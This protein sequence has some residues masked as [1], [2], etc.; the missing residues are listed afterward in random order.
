[1]FF[2]CFV[3]L[4]IFIFVCTSV[5]LLPPGESPNA[6]SSSSSSSSKCLSLCSS[7]VSSIFSCDRTVASYKAN[8]PDC[9]IQC[10]RF[11]LSSV[12]YRNV[13]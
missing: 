13:L 12:S 5:G 4:C 3:V 10:F 7:L 6:V 11:P 8:Y 1:M 2:L 9:A